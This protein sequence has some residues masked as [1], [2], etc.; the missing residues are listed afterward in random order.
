MTDTLPCPRCSTPVALASATGTD[1]TD[2]SGGRFRLERCSNCEA[3]LRRPL[4]LDV[5]EWDV[6]KEP[7]KNLAACIADTEARL[8]G[9][10]AQA[11]EGRGAGEDVAAIEAQI[12]KLERVLIVVRAM[13]RGLSRREQE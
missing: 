6:L 5:G 12:A 1:F 9:A 8:A 13:L 7:Q 10:H 2:S 4:N 3:I 11:D